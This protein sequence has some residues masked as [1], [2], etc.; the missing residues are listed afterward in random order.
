[1]CTPRN[2]CLWAEKLIEKPTGWKRF[3]GQRGKDDAFVCA[4]STQMT[5]MFSKL[6]LPKRLLKAQPS[7]EEQH[8]QPL[9]Q[10]VQPSG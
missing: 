5:T 9:S 1:M 3:T 6:P 8:W 7:L 10:L 4:G 2:Y